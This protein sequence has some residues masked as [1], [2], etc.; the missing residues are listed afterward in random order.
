MILQL[1]AKLLLL[2]SGGPIF[3][4]RLIEFVKWTSIKSHFQCG[5]FQVERP[6]TL[7]ALYPSLKLIS[8][9]CRSRGHILSAGETIKKDVFDLNK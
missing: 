2:K 6:Q 4:R 1:N 9:Y 3:L 5:K 7:I 8:Q